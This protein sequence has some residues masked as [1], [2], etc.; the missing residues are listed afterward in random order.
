MYRAGTGEALVTEALGSVL[1]PEGLP[2][3]VPGPNRANL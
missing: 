2:V 1:S 3:P